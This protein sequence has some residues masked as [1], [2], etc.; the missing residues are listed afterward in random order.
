[1]AQ[2]VFGPAAVV[3]VLNRAFTNTSPSNAVFAN[4][5]ATAGTTE[6]SQLAFAKSFGASFATGKTAAD[7]SALLMTNMGITNAALSAALTDYIAANGTQNVGII[8]W[9]LSSI[10]S[11]LENDGTYGAAAK[12]WNAEV[13]AA[14]EYSA[15]VKNTT[16]STGSTTGNEAGKSLVLT[17]AQDVLTGTAGADNFRAV[18]G[19]TDGSQDQ[20][21]LNSSDIIDGGAGADAIIVN[22]TGALYQGG[23]RI[24]NIETLQLGTN[25][26]AATFDYNVNAGSNE[27]TEVTTIVADQ[28]NTGEVLS[29]QNI[30]RTDLAGAKVAPTLSWVNDSNTQAAGVV[31]YTYRAAE[32]TGAADEQKVSLKS[33]NNGDINLS[34]GFETISITSVGTEQV[35]LQP[36][37]DNV[38]AD[39]TS[40]ASLRTVNLAG[41]A[42]IGK[43]AGVLASGLTD[44]VVGADG[45][46]VA[47]QSNLLSVAAVAT[48]V[49][50]STAEAAVNV[51]FTNTAAS[52]N[53]FLGGA[54][55]DY[56]EFELGNIAA[57]GGA[58]NDTFAFIN[59]G[60]NSTFGEGDS[61]DGGAGSDTIQI[62]LNGAGTY[63]ISETELRN[64]SSVGEIDLRGS[65]TTLT[66]SSDFVS[67]ADTADSIT[68]RTDKVVQTSLT[69]AANGTSTTPLAAFATEDAVT[70]TVNLTML[71]SNQSV[72]FVGGSGS[73]RIIM[74]DATFNKL[75][76][77]NG[78]NYTEGNTGSIFGAGSNRYDTIT[79]VTNGENVVIDAEDLSNVSDI[80]GFVLTKNSAAA[81]YNIT[82]TRAFMNA[83]TEAINNAT[84]TAINDTVFQIGTSN[85]A[86]NSAL[87]SADT[88][89]IDVRDLLNATDAAAATGFTRLL[90]VTALENAGLGANLRF[91]GNTGNLTLAQVRAAGVVVANGFDANFADVVVNS[92]AVP[93]A[94]PLFFQGTVA[95]ES[96]TLVANGNSVDMGGGAD[97]LNTGAALAPVGGLNGGAGVDIL[98]AAAGVNLTGATISNF[99]TLNLN[100]AATLNA[101]QYAAFTTVTAAGLADAVTLATT[102]NVNGFAAVETYNLSAAGNQITLAG[103]TAQTING[104]AAAAND[105]VV[106]TAANS[107]N[108][109]IALGLGNDTLTVT[110]DFAGAWTLAA[111]GAAG[112]AVT[113]VET[114]NLQGGT[115]TGALTMFNGAATVNLTSVLGQAAGGVILGSGGQTV[116]VLGTTSGA[117]TITGAAGQDAV[118]LSGVGA[119]GGAVTIVEGAATSLV[120]NFTTITGFRAGTDKIDAVVPGGANQLTTINVAAST[121]L[122][123]LAGALNNAV[124]QAI[125]LA[126]ANWNAAGDALIVNIAA[127]TA[128]GTYYVQNAAADVL[129]DANAELVV[130]LV[131][132][133]GV[134]TQADIV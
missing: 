129:F 69:N 102:G 29:V 72:N 121:S 82:L 39:V 90:D 31:N 119:A 109:T 85:A 7:L 22:L 99:E 68:V 131:G 1:M 63:N 6:A 120:T 40:G 98:N 45:T 130:K 111:A 78:G 73:D 71:S 65:N 113:G 43:N 57:N 33:V 50:A 84:N 15:D 20:T 38:V 49:D 16:P 18:A 11:N 117:Y 79:V 64:K 88:V 41:T 44:R 128:A 5:V 62:G 17:V 25:I 116:N 37:A 2:Q 107:A 127:G 91:I 8:A 61:I 54:G 76:T 66:L 81:T 122:A 56:V 101:A 36:G 4:Q 32:L 97:T 27:I 103:N 77:I 21:T 110:S 52:N 87:N 132:T 133:V 10:L 53:T 24:K 19:K 126:A 93:G 47:T 125:T 9:Q 42:E 114:V 46:G 67:K 112:A 96:V 105:T 59:T 23:A 34:A 58:G 14:Y 118:N 3:S 74:N 30:V 35:T 134:I 115:S 95:D 75:K 89:T 26:A 70:N 12:A 60:A 124:G 13:T 123:D 48:K 92:A 108:K 100:G 86:N 80:E 55:N 28:I 94:A 106:T 104:N 83:N 51:R